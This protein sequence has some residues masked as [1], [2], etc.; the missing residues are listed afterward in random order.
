MR[1]CPD[2]GFEFDDDK[3]FCPSCGKYMPKIENPYEP[4]F[5]KSDFAE[6][7]PKSGVNK[8]LIGTDTD[9]EFANEESAENELQPASAAMPAAAVSTAAPESTPSVWSFVLS[10]FLMGIPLVGLVYIIVLAC[11]GTKYPVKKN[12]ARALFLYYFLVLVIISA[13]VLVLMLALG[14]S[15]L[16]ELIYKIMGINLLG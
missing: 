15:G 13:L 16:T 5:G 12:F 3:S 9:N 11:G 10:L 8:E 6:V 2:C 14:Q 7:S 1:K 4:N